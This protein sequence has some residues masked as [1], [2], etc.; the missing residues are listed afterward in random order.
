MPLETPTYHTS[1]AF[2]ILLETEVCTVR[3]NHSEYAITVISN[4]NTH[5]GLCQA[6]KATTRSHIASSNAIPYLPGNI[7]DCVDKNIKYT[8]YTTY[9]CILCT[10]FMQVQL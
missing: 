9:A 3:G 7:N 1:A 5:L 10:K 4:C 2:P 6:V 8:R